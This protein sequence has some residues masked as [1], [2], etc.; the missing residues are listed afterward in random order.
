[1][2]AVDLQLL[3]KELTTAGVPH[4]FG[5]GA[6]NSTLETVHTWDATGTRAPL[7]PAADPVLAAHVAP[8][9]VIE[10]AEQGQ[11]SGIV[12]TTN[13]TPTEVFRFGCLARH[14]YRANLRLSG[15]DAGNG[16]TRT[17]EARF[18]WKMPTTTPVIIGSTV[19]SNIADTAAAS[20]AQSLSVAG[21]DVVFTVTGAAGRTIDWLL[22][23][24]I[25]TY[26]PEGL[27]A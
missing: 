17:V 18:A 13:A 2:T 9:A 21:T 23:G 8:P 1:M 16:T 12:R 7:P 11:V 14:V 19:V 27:E 6:A 3:S 20:W 26:A 10:Y 24:E 4:P 22:I 5:L 25:G 15:V